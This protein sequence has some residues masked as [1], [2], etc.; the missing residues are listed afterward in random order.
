[1]AFGEAFYDD[2]NRGWYAYEV[3]K[4]EEEEEEEKEVVKVTSE[5]KRLSPIEILKKQGEDFEMALSEAVLNPTP[6]NYRDYLEKSTAI[7]QQAETF[8]LGFKQSIWQNPEFDY[9]LEKPRNTAGIVTYNKERNKANST[10]LSEFSKDKAFLF[11]YRSDCPYCH[12][13]A[14]ILKKFSEYYGWDVLPISIDDAPLLPEYPEFKNDV[15]LG[16][17]LNITVVPAL[18]MVEPSSSR[19]ATVSY[20]MTDWSELTDKT[21]FAAEQ[22]GDD[23]QW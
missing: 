8:A 4:E 5:S 20:G 3:I 19:V 23:S 13:F 15:E 10:A 1:M 12:E 16:K 6:E 18:F 21:I 14:P 2:R 17:K 22:I 7:Q 9:T 11:F